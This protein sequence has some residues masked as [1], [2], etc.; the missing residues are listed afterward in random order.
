MLSAEGS[1]SEQYKIEMIKD[2]ERGRWRMEG[3]KN[4]G[5]MPLLNANRL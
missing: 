2:G 4:D 3:I 1:V 5:K